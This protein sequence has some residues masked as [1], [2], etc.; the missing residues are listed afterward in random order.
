MATFKFKGLDE[1]VRKLESLEGHTE[2]M[3]GEAIYNGADVVADSVKKA[4]ESLPVD[5][6][7]KAD[8]KTSISELQKKG[9]IASFG[10]AKLKDDRGFRNVKLGFD[11]YNKVKTKK[12]PQGQ[13]NVMIA[14]SLESG[15]SYMP[16]NRVIS[17]A[18][19]S[20]KKECEKKMQETIEQS[21]NK[22][23]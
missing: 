17:K 10:I 2:E 20:A 1:Y 11:G 18:A 23:M 4:L 6:R 21:I 5:N 15:T 8:Q 7:I 19:N 12:Y 9:L 22:I 16:K 14:R 13:P 3:L